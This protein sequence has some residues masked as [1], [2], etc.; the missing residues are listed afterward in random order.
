MMV[1]CEF[2][3]YTFGYKTIPMDN[4]V[5]APILGQVRSRRRHAWD[6]EKLGSES[7]LM[8]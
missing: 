2:T 4:A 8:A 7:E 3:Q 6:L 5:A 1:Q